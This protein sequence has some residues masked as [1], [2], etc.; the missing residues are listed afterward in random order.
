MA[1]N[2]IS[3]LPHLTSLNVQ[4]RA[5]VEYEPRPFKLGLDG[6]VGDQAESRACRSR[7]ARG[8]L[9]GIMLGST[10]YGTALILLGIIKL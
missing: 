4:R 1:H 7:A 3:T 5:P 9:L 6:S 10:I 2:V 8:A